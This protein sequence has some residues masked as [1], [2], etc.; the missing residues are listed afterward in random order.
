[1]KE[2][3]LPIIG[4]EKLYEISNTGKV[5]SLER[6]HKWGVGICTTKEKLLKDR[7]N[8]IYSRVF[9]SKDNKLKHFTIHRLV[10]IHFIP[11]PNNYPIVMH[12]D[13]NPKNNHY[14]NLMWGT[15]Y[16]NSQDMKQKGRARN[17]YTSF[18]KNLY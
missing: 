13:D 7:G 5:K 15:K 3:W 14:T 2:L 4:Y 12:K 1:M 16:L 10:A 17:Q 18:N 8:G 11:N 6:K 9:L